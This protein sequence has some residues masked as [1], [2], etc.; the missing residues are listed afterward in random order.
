MMPLCLPG[1]TLF[2]RAMVDLHSRECNRALA[3]LP[4]VQMGP[5]PE[6]A[7]NACYFFNR[8]DR[9]GLRFI[10][11]HYT[12]GPEQ[13]DTSPDAAQLIAFLAHGDLPPA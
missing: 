5:S 12:E 13:M 4:L 11:Y 1:K 2:A 10:S 6:S 7:R 3:L 8:V 9:E